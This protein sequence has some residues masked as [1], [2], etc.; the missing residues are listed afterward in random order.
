[1]SCEIYILTET[2][3]S[4]VVNY[5]CLPNYNTHYTT[6]NRNQNDGVVVYTKE[7]LDCTVAEVDVVDATCITIVVGRD[8]VVLAIYRSPSETNIKPFLNSL[9]NLLTRY[10]DKMNI[11]LMVDLNINVNCNDDED[12]SHYMSVLAIHGLLPGHTF[13]T[14]NNNCLDHAILKSKFPAMTLVME[15]PLTDHSAVMTAVVLKNKII[16]SVNTPTFKI[17]YEEIV[18]EIIKKDFNDIIHSKDPNWLAEQLITRLNTAILNNTIRV[19]TPRST[20]CLK[21]WI[22]PGLIRCI[23]N[24]DRMHLKFKQESSN[25]VLK[26]THNRYKNYCNDLLKRLKRNYERNLLNKH[27]KNPKMK[28]KIINKIANRNNK[29]SSPDELLKTGITPEDSLERINHYFADVG[30]ELAEKII[31]YI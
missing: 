8:T 29:Q 6:K 16:K 14:R 3:N 12:S 25:I 9:N 10:K 28:W 2:W 21:P 19:I 17:N 31:R 13:P 24:R 5:P 1:M 30:K 7:V 27:V 26:I 23:N 18:N 20:R 11:I 22:T 4:K 15:A